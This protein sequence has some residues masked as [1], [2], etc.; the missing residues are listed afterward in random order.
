MNFKTEE[1]NF[2]TEEM[3]FRTDIILVLDHKQELWAPPVQDSPG[4]NCSLPLVLGKKMKQ[5]ELASNIIYL[6]SIK[7]SP[8][9]D[10]QENWQGPVLTSPFSEETQEQDKRCRK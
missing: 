9:R 2:K 4:I 10:K 7:G 8:E 3:N 5:E 1:M 6:P